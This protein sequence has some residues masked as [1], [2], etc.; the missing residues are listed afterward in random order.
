MVARRVLLSCTRR[1]TVKEDVAV[2]PRAQ[3]SDNLTAR[4]IRLY[5]YTSIRVQP[6]PSKIRAQRPMPTYLLLGCKLPAVQRARAGGRE[7]G[8]EQPV[9]GGR[10]EDGVGDKCTLLR[11]VFGESEPALKRPEDTGTSGTCPE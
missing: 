3:V 1:R 6:K 9:R 8:T 10:L 5:D 11:A 7:E 4:T 2:L